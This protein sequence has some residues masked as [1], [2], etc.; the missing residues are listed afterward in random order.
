[1]IEALRL[2]GEPN[3]VLSL[4]FGWVRIKQ[5]FVENIPTET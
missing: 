5:R 4:V 3:K 1:V 2:S